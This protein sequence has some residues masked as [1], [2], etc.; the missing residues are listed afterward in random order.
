MHKIAISEAAM[1]RARTR[2]GK[3]H[4]FDTIDP[5]RTA[6]LV[7]DMQN[8]FVKAGHQGEV[9][10]ARE[11][12]PNINRL[13]AELRRRGGHVVWIRNG[14]TDTRQSW[15]TYHDWL[16][17]PECMQRRY[18]AMEEGHDG[19][20]FWHL[21]DI[22]PEDVRLT[23]TRYSAFI[24]GSSAIE[25]HLREH[26]IDTVLIA[27]TATNICCE[28]TARDAMMLNF[29]TVMVAD[30]LAANSDEEHNASLSALYGQFADV[31]TVDDVLQ[32]LKRGDKARAAA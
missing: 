7:I 29:K 23:K 22:R 28:S 19:F 26:E 9:P 21:N 12:V 3:L 20:E 13:A 5:L 2:I 15:S 25:T 8:Y 4:P 11:I 10:L 14:S 17:T 30:A 27:G 6:L 31:Q 18:E 16:M 1:T 32:S 24:Q